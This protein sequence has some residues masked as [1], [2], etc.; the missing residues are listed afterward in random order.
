MEGKN[1]LTSPTTTESLKIFF[2][3]Q[4]FDNEIKISDGTNETTFGGNSFA[5]A[6][7]ALSGASILTFTGDL[8]LTNNTLGYSGSGDNSDKSFSLGGISKTTDISITAGEAYNIS[9][10]SANFATNGA[11]ITNG[12]KYT[13]YLGGDFSNKTFT[14]SSKADSIVNSG[15]KLTID[16]GAGNDSIVNKGST[17]SINGGAGADSISNENGGDN[18]TLNGGDGNDLLIGQSGKVDTFIFTAG[19]DSISGYENSDATADIVSLASGINPPTS[20][21]RFS[22]GSSSA[23]FTLSGNRYLTFTDTS[24]KT[25]SFKLGNTITYNYTASSIAINTGGE[26]ATNAISL[27]SNFKSATYDLSGDG[28]TSYD[29]INASAANPSSITFTILNGS[30]SSYIVGSNTTETS[31][32]GGAGNDT[33]KAG[34]IGASLDGGGGSNS[35]VGEIGEDLFVYSGGNDTISNYDISSDI[36][37]LSG[38]SAILD[39]MKV[40]SFSINDRTKGLKLTFGGTSI[41]TFD[42]EAVSIN[43]GEK[44]TYYYAN[45][46]IFHNGTSISLGGSSQGTVFSATGTKYS[47][48]VTINA[49]AITSEIRITGNGNDN[50]IVGSNTAFVSLNGGAGNDTILAGTAGAILDGGADDDSLVGS[51]GSD[52]FVFNGGLDSITGFNFTKQDLVSLTG[53]NFTPEKITNISVSEANLVLDF[54]EYNKITFVGGSASSIS[55]ASGTTYYTLDKNSIASGKSI[56]LTS[57]YTTTESAFNSDGIY[58][59][60]KASSVTSAITIAGNDDANYIVGS[61]KGGSIDSGAGHDSIDVSGRDDNAEFIFRHTSGNDSINGFDGSKDKLTIDDTSSIKNAKLSSGKI[62]FTVDTKKSLILKGDNLEKVSLTSNDYLTKDGVVT[63]GGTSSFK[64]FS[65]ASGKIDLTDTLYG[66]SSIASVNASEVRNQS[67]TLV[68]DE[69]GGSFTFYDKNKKKDVLAYNGGSVTVT[70]YEAGKDKIS[71]GADSIV[72][73][74]IATVTVNEQERKDVKLSVSD[75]GE[76][77]LVG[78]AGSEVLVQH[79]I[80]KNSKM[81]F[82]DSNVLQDKDKRP[83]AVTI[84]SAHTGDYTAPDTVK[85]ITL[86]S[87]VTGTTITAG[88]KNNTT[89]DANKAGDVTLVGGKKDDKLIG[90]TLAANVFVYKA[91]EAGGNKAGKDIIEGFDSSDSVSLGAEFK[92]ENVQK[93]AAGSTSVKLTFDNNNTLTIKGAKGQLDTIKVNN[94]NAEAT[95]YSFKKNAI[96]SGGIASLTSGAS[97][98]VK[99]SSLGEGVHT[100][101]ASKV[102][103]NN[104]TLTGTTSADSIVSGGKKATLQGGGGNDVLVGGDGKD[105]FFYSKNAGDVTIQKFDFANDNLKIANGTI[106]KIESIS[107]GV[108]FI[109]TDGKKGSPNSA[110]FSV[111]TSISG[112]DSGAIDPNKIA[113]KA[114][115]TYYWFAKEDVEEEVTVK[116]STDKE[117]IKVAS[118]GDLITSSTVKKSDVTSAGYGIID[119]GYSTNLT[120]LTNGVSVAIKTKNAKPTA[121]T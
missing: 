102:T 104:L 91:A 51:E 56:T 42:E 120:K 50:Y 80:N 36:V 67:I 69:S 108:K 37:S 4:R 84:L 41:L 47:D 38:I 65:S 101:D 64:L 8:T 1:F 55:L 7:G 105:T 12:G 119:L 88:N 24:A 76:I 118:A 114:N 3:L 45:N 72:S 11:S 33:L 32:K 23:T 9:L 106:S 78:A 94:N 96:I 86:E 111:N 35:L 52:T 14:G 54:N 90:S 97:G 81:I 48:L 110:S 18:V 40:E 116:G 6:M 98:G 25:F 121:T 77:S 43:S 82:A 17:V 100:V 27:T 20:E 99:L 61:N 115:N 26:S 39:P 21:N 16:G 62:T 71:L 63:F 103:K 117:T 89:V 73:F 83:T 59:S 31:I 22:I 79:S 93:V 66:G 112:S 28:A 19:A 113:I 13:F 46:L 68:A 85:K 53:S 92:L 57:N 29:S 87:G 74:E 15:T 10:T 49:S 30:H 109:M 95:N 34:R 75:G 58:D 2:D 5:F 60:I 107:G 70:N 44:D